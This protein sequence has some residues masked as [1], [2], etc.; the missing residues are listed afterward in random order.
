M[1]A[2]GL[3]LLNDS[4]QMAYR[5]GQPIES[6]DDQGFAW[7]DFAKQTRQNWPGA[8]GARRVFLEHGFAARGA[9]FVKLWICSLLVGGHARVADHTAGEGGFPG[10]RR[11]FVN[12]SSFGF[13]FYNSTGYP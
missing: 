7:L 3:K 5:P 10:F 13:G 4:E 1:R 2:L 8:I 6:D 11:H 12:R 9:E